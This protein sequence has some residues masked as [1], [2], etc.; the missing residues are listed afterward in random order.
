MELSE[1][2][3]YQ[4]TKRFSRAKG[5]PANCECCPLTALIVALAS[6]QQARCRINYWYVVMC[7]QLTLLCLYKAQSNRSHSWFR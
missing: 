3:E 4:V 7:G 2:I 1:V 6:M 5:Q